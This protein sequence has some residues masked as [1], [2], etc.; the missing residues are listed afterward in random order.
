MSPMHDLSSVI[1]KLAVKVSIANLIF[2][3]IIEST[4]MNDHILA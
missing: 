1:G 2:R 3:D 4:Q